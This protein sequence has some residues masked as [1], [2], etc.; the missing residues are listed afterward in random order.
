MG[1]K[2]RKKMA[3]GGIDPI[4]LISVGASLYN[5]REAKLAQ[6]AAAS[7][8]KAEQDKQRLAMD[9]I[10]LENFNQ[11]GTDKYF[12][13]NGGMFQLNRRSDGNIKGFK[14]ISNDVMEVVGPKHENGG[15]PFGRIS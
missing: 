7:F 15:V 12:Y 6:D 14:P 5:N 2:K 3:L 10:A 1:C 8:A 13:A 11:S 9:S 4:S